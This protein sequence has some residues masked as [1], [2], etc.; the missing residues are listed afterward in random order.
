VK[1]SIKGNVLTV[2]I[3]V[4]TTPVASKTGKSMI[5]ATS[6]G[7][8]AVSLTVNGTPTVVKIGVNAFIPSG[9]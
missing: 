2:E 9:Q 5:L 3:P 7:N 8:Q 4:N 6:N 1:A